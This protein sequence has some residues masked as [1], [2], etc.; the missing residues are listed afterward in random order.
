MNNEALRAY[1]VQ[2][3]SEQMHWNTDAATFIKSAS[4]SIRSSILGQLIN[5][6]I[7]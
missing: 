2:A 6:L 7:N 1:I 4:V 5:H 3:M